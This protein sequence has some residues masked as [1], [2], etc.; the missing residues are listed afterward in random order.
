MKRRYII[1]VT[2]YWEVDVD[3]DDEKLDGHRVAQA[4][5][6]FDLM[7]K[8]VQGTGRGTDWLDSSF[9]EDTGFDIISSALVE[10]CIETADE[11]E[12]GVEVV[13]V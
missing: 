6:K 13:E 4:F 2:E 1:E 12:Y 8:E 3:T 9:R 11:N 10:E 7:P 5:L